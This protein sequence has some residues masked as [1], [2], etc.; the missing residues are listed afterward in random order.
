LFSREPI[1]LRAFSF[2]AY[3]FSNLFLKN[4]VLVGPLEI[5]VRNKVPGG[6]IHAGTSFLLVRKEVP[7]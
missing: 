1:L 3:F 7:A 6:Y 4:I 2:G 5:N